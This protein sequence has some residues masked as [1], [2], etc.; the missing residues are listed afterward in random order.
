MVTGGNTARRSGTIVLRDDLQDD[1]LFFHFANAFLNKIE[2]P[3]F[4]SCG[5]EFGLESAELV[6][7]NLTIRPAAARHL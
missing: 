3:H 2:G 5:N 6:H 4:T 1:V 7:E